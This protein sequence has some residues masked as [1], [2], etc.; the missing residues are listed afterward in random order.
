MRALGEGIDDAARGKGGDEQLLG[1]GEERRQRRAGTDDQSAGA[2]PGQPGQ[3]PSA[4]IDGESERRRH[5]RIDEPDAR[6]EHPGEH[7][8]RR[9]AERVADRA[10][11]KPIIGQKRR[12]LSAPEKPLEQ[13][14]L[15]GFATAPSKRVSAGWSSDRA[16]AVGEGPV[17][18]GTILTLEASLVTLPPCQNPGKRRRAERPRTSAPPRPGKSALPLPSAP[19][20]PAAR[21]SRASAPRPRP[22]TIRSLDPRRA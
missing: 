9:D 13:T 19:I 14:V 17:A 2:H 22:P 21:P 1:R 12:Y 7:D 3:G 8:E 16:A 10:G 20:S 11:R 5:Q 18:L 15:S 4:G 6:L